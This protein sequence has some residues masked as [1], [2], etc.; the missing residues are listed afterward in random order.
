M[1]IELTETQRQAI[2]NAGK[3]LPRVVDTGTNTTYVLVR[4]D[5]FERL[6]GTLDDEFDPRQAYP[7]IDRAFAEGWDDPKMDEYDRY[8]ELKR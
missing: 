1:N 6:Q 3:K 4:A 7:A 5:V 2:A 8:E